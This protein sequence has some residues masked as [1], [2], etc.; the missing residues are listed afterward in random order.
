MS[1]VTWMN[2]K[3]RNRQDVSAVSNYLA[4]RGFHRTDMSNEANTEPERL[5][6]Y[7]EVKDPLAWLNAGLP[8]LRTAGKT[9]FDLAAERPEFDLEQYLHI[10]ASSVE[11]SEATAEVAE[12]GKERDRERVAISLKAAADSV[13]PKEDQ[14]CSWGAD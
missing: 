1:T 3:D 10:L 12:G 7:D 4:I 11:G 13:A 6:V 14:W 5:E 2:S 8:D 9:Q